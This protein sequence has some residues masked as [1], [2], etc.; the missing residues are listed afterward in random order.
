MQLFQAKF[1]NEINNDDTT[2]NKSSSVLDSTSTGGNK[3]IQFIS[4]F[5]KC[6]IRLF[7]ILTSS[8]IFFILFKALN[9]EFNIMNEKLDVFSKEIYETSKQEFSIINFE[10]LITKIRNHVS[11]SVWSLIVEKYNLLS[12]FQKLKDMFLIGRGELYATFFESA[13]A[14]LNKQ[15]DQNFEFV[16][17]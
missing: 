6:K 13:K 8:F 12:E 11:E 10:N 2:I 4:E 14:L 16:V 3:T 1:L 5:D 7:Q 9:N 17:N 15:V